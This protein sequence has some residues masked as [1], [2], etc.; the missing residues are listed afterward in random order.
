M[1]RRALYG[2]DGEVIDV[3]ALRR[4]EGGATTMGVRQVQ[5]EHPSY[6]L[7]PEGLASILRTS[8]STDPQRFFALCADIEEREMH[9]R[10]VLGTRKAAVAQLEISVEPAAVPGGVRQ[11]DFVR[12]F[13]ERPEFVLALV[14][15]LDALGKGISWSEI[16]WDVS[17]GQFQPRKLALR[18]PRWFRFAQHDLATGLLLDANGQPQ[19]LKPYKWVTHQP[20]LLSGIPIRNGLTRAAAYGWMFKNFSLKSWLIFLEVYG[21]PLRLGR[22][23]QN[24][25]AAEKRTL[26]R[27]VSEL[28]S[29]AAAIVPQTM[30][31]EFIDAPTG[32]G[33][34]SPF[35]DMAE[36][37]DLQASKLVLGQ[38]GTTDAVAGGSRGLGA[39]QNT[40]REDIERMDALQLAAT[41]NRDIARPMVDLNFGP[42]KRYPTV[43]IGRPEQKD[44]KLILDNIEKLVDRG[45]RVEEA[46]V[47]DLLG[48]E[49]PA[50]GAVLLRPRPVSVAKPGEQPGGASSSE[51]D[52]ADGPADDDVPTAEPDEPDTVAAAQDAD[53]RDWADLTVDQL[54]ADGAWLPDTDELE[55]ELAACASVEEAEKVL[56]AHLDKLGIEKLAELIGQARFMA[57]GTAITER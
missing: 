38:T 16:V 57:R 28:G 31:I 52:R 1:A 35:K 34:G 9:Y 53:R 20:K 56:A 24:A 39:V 46:Q 25:T 12:E 27:A 26:L 37:F 45:V 17:E 22:Y 8:E 54:I 55:R 40:V 32:N 15:A 21:H 19:P 13:V 41:V 30:N 29:D 10:S 7:S 43:R 18:D 23:P 50:E 33:G 49:E 4:E 6:G 44:V 14:D 11:A 47:L 51:G 42:Q 48:L 3:E 36:Y 2:P 5:P